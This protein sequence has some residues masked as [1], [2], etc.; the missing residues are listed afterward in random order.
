MPGMKIF[1]D[2]PLVHTAREGYLPPRFLQANSFIFDFAR[3]SGIFTVQS[4]SRLPY[5]RSRRG[6]RSARALDEVRKISYLLARTPFHHRDFRYGGDR[7]R[8]KEFKRGVEDKN[9]GPLV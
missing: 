2:T 9:I 5:L 8:F 1:T 6:V 4:P 7:S 3:R